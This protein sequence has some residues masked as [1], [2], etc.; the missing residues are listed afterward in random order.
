MNPKMCPILTAA[1]LKP[2]VESKILPISGEKQTDTGF[3]AVPCAG[4]ACAMYQPITDAANRVVG[5]NCALALIP[6]S[7]SMLNES[8]RAAA[9]LN[10]DR[11]GN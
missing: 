4:P 8:I 1:L 11:K 5:G 9:A 3:D 10:P 2:R 7:V 6:V